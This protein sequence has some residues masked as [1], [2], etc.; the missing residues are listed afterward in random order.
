MIHASDCFHVNSTKDILSA[1]GGE[2][3][4]NY[5]RDFSEWLSLNSAN[6]MNHEKNAQ[7]IGMV[8]RVLET[9][10]RCTN[11]P[12]KKDLRPCNTFSYSQNVR[13]HLIPA[14]NSVIITNLPRS[15]LYQSANK[16][17]RKNQSFFKAFS[18]S[19]SKGI[20]LDGSVY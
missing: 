13:G 2:W 15:Y 5:I 20:P 10:D 8:S 14:S 4:Y 17:L 19:K 9:Q 7:D 11:G 1:M 3:N 18:T 12:H 16:I 6:L